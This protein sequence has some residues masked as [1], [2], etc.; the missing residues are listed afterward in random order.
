MQG[1]SLIP[2]WEIKVPHA[3]GCAAKKKKKIKLNQANSHKYPDFQHLLTESLAALGPY[4]HMAVMG[5]DKYRV[6]PTSP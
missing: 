2:G 6:L 1:V 3:V 5:A 4:S